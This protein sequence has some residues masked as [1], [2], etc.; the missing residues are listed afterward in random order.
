ML[1]ELPGSKNELPV[2]R[3]AT[4]LSSEVTRGDRFDFVR[5]FVDGWGRR[6][7]C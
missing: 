1:N 2:G 5:R 4:Q 3:A 7:V 6:H